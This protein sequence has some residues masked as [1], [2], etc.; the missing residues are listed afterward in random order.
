MHRLL[1]SYGVLH[2]TCFI[3]ADIS[4]QSEL[5]IPQII[6]RVTEGFFVFCLV[7]VL[8]WFDEACRRNKQKYEGNNQRAQK[9]Y[10]CNWTFPTCELQEEGSVPIVPKDAA[11]VSQVLSSLTGL[12]S[13]AHIQWLSAVF[14]ESDFPLRCDDKFKSKNLVSFIPNL[15]KEFFANL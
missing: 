1:L 13:N 4:Q 9:P 11:H 5:L 3:C 2:Y 14:S 12:W 10:C 7:L 8:L 6:C 15:S